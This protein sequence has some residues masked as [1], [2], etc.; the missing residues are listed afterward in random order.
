MWFDNTAC[1]G[2]FKRELSIENYIK[3]LKRNPVIN[4]SITKHG[5][6][7]IWED[8]RKK[9]NNYT[10]NNGREFLIHN[11]QVHS[12]ENI[13][14][15]LLSLSQDISFITSVFL[16]I[17]ILIKPDISAASDYADYLTVGLEPPD[18][19]QYWV[20]PFITEYINQVVIKLHPELKLFLKDNNKYRMQ[21]E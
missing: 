17:L 2:Q 13:S 10:H 4:K 21:I 8:I 15:Y 7:P 6:N 12:N 3:Y 14:K 9:L 1:S 19:S 16:V 5:L 18:D 20:A 11:S